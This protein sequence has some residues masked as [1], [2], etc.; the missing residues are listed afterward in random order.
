MDACLRLMA[1]EGLSKTDLARLLGV[2]KSTIS[3]ILR[4]DRL[5][6]AVR[7]RIRASGQRFSRR[8]LSK[9]AEG[10]DELAQAEVLDLLLGCPAPE[11]RARRKGEAQTHRFQDGQRHFVLKL[12]PHERAQ[13]DAP[14]AITVKGIVDPLHAMELF[15]FLGRSLRGDAVLNQAG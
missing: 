2:T 7:E 9:V 6:P 12:S 1:E 8:Q 4:L 15:Q 13:E 11:S 14:V 5:G 10:A 3:N